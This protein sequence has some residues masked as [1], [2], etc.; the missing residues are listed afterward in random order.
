M[1]H[2][3]V[4]SQQVVEALRPETAMILADLTLGDGGHSLALLQRMPLQGRV[5]ALDLDRD[6]IRRAQLRLEEFSTRF[7]PMQGN[8]REVK[9]LFQQAGIEQVDGLVADLGISSLQVTDASKGFS[10]SAK[11]P[12]SMRMDGASWGT[13]EQVI[14][15][16]DEKRLA[17][18]IWQYGEERNNRKIAAA[19]VRARGQSPIRDTER[20][21]QVIKGVVP[22]RYAIKTLARVFQAF[23]IYVN[24]ELENL[25]AMLPQAL[26]L[27]RS[28]GRAVFISYHSLEDKEIKFFMHSHQQPCICPPSLPICVCHRTADIK[29]IGRMISVAA[30]EREKNKSSRSARMR[31][32]EKL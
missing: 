16:S 15:E 11:G 8:F 26:A 24:D 6:A 9:N 4:L 18:I 3:S 28:G 25:R 10:F 22:G 32:L 7:F 19:L 5:V 14:N 30:E 2:V 21:A 27:L 20:L 1:Y 29:I 12:L 13:A 17:D 31:V 23:R